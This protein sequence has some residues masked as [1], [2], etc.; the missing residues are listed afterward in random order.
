MAI[1]V[2]VSADLGRFFGA[3]LRA[4]VLNRIFERT[5]DRDA[6]EQALKL[7]HAARETWAGTAALTRNIYMADITVGEAR[8]LRGH[9]ASLLR[10]FRHYPY[11]RY[12]YSR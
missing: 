9:W 3:K 6:L 8:Q 12:G 4:G 5:G 7:Y 2:A 1:D 10:C 11:L